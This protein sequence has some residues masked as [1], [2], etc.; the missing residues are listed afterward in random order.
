M[1][2]LSEDSAELLLERLP[3]RLETKE[4]RDASALRRW[5][6]PELR[7]ILDAGRA[8]AEAALLRDGGCPG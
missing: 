3:V 4:P 1:R 6:V 7:A 8:E 5:L 2:Q